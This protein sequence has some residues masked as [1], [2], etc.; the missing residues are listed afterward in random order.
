MKIKDRDSRRQRILEFYPWLKAIVKVFRYQRIEEAMKHTK[1]TPTT[2]EAYRQTQ[3]TG[4]LSWMLLCRVSRVKL[5]IR[6]K[7]QKDLTEAGERQSG[8]NGQLELKL[9]K[10]ITQKLIVSI[11]AMYNLKGKLQVA[12]L[13]IDILRIGSASKTMSNSDKRNLKIARMLSKSIR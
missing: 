12:N 7:R 5:A 10:S 9:P 11:C 8:K 1:G 3:F 13:Q 4:I 2:M 6:W